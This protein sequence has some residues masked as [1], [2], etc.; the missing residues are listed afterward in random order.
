M[1]SRNAHPGDLAYCSQDC[2]G[3]ITHVEGSKAVGIHLDPDNPAEV[4]VG[5]AWLSKR[6]RII[7]NVS[8]ILNGQF[9]PGPMREA[10]NALLDL[11]IACEKQK[12][13]LN[14]Q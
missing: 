2:L 12:D 9:P 3:L 5:S 10:H 1:P 8:T 14:A 7:G 6:P 11:V 13:I 4:E